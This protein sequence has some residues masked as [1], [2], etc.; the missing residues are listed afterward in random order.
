MKNPLLFQ[1]WQDTRRAF[2]MHKA[3]PG[4]DIEG[5]DRCQEISTIDVCARCTRFARVLHKPL[6]VYK[7][8]K[9]SKRICFNFRG[10][11][12]TPT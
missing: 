8:Y 5:D 3:S 10:G 11:Y 4:A 9:I 6:D 7:F 2:A 12:R 1:A